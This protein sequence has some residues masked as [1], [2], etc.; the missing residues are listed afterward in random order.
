M[1]F[2]LIDDLSVFIYILVYSKIQL[3]DGLHMVFVKK[4]AMLN[5]VGI[6]W[7]LLFPSNG[8]NKILVMTNIILKPTAL[9]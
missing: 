3:Y 7:E 2:V 1:G 5:N 8:Q 6:V 4:R 9:H